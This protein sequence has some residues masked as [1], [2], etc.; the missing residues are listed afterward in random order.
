MNLTW[1]DSNS[2]LMEIANKRILLDPWLVGSLTFG[3]LPWLF[4]GE[5]TKL[6]PIPENIDLILLS[7]GLED[8]A[9]PPTLA[10]LERAIP[11]V[12]SPNGA[13]VVQELGYKEINILKPGEKFVL[14]QKIEIIA[15]PGSPIGP[16][17]IENGYLIKDLS[18]G[19]TLYYEPHGYHSQLIKETSDIDA[20]ITPIVDLKLP[21]LG[22]VIQGQK[23][24]LE[25]CRAVSP[26]FIIPTAA[27]GDVAFEGLLMYLLRTEG[28]SE[29]FRDLLV[30]NN[31]K[32]QVI[33][34]KPGESFAIPPL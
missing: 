10:E 3:N 22:S 29:Q 20:V 21:I 34:P 12:A 26:Q 15:V 25:L 2:W 16:Q 1:L 11:V 23:S 24:A 14:D 4:K 17:L 18:N 5:K 31:L 6:R 27:G 13:K 30:E 8:H 9:H 32:T 7:Q 28:T 19:Y 33:D